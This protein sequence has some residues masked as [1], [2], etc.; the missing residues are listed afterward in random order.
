MHV[1]RLT[2]SHIRE[3]LFLWST[4]LF[5][6]SI[7][8]TYSSKHQTISSDKFWSWS[9]ECRFM[10]CS[11]CSL[12]RCQFRESQISLGVLDGLVSLEFTIFKNNCFYNVNALV[13]STV[14]SWHFLVHL[15]YCSIKSDISILS[16]H[17][18]VILSC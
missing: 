3:K 13:S 8:T 14:S 12:D 10:S 1:Y 16:V 7:G 11:G 9:V 18:H 2:D 15:R 17:V 6:L 4:Q 5:V